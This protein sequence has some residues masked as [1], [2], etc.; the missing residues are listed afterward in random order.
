MALRRR[1][2]LLVALGSSV[3]LVM[4]T[5]II[6]IRRGRS[7][8]MWRIISVMSSWIVR[9]YRRGVHVDFRMSVHV[10]VLHLSFDV[11]FV[12]VFFSFFHGV[13]TIMFVSLSFIVRFF[14]RRQLLPG[15]SYQSC[16]R[17]S[18]R[19]NTTL[20]LFQTQDVR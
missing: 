12:L 18:F 4:L 17:A 15:C 2:L 3:P 7:V 13:H 9:V 6:S 5:V 16:D 20:S 1:I 11:F 14:F 19:W 8:H 10:V